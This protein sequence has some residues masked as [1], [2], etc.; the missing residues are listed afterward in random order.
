MITR[1][2]LARLCLTFKASL[3]HLVRDS[4]GEGCLDVQYVPL[5][6]TLSVPTEWAAA[7]VISL[8][9]STPHHLRLMTRP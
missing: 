7:R 6:A 3:V 5:A 2:L 9:H 1:R 8:I 4:F